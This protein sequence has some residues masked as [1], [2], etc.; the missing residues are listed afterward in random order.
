VMVH[1]CE[2]E[3]RKNLS[4]EEGRSVIDLVNCQEGRDE[5]SNFQVGNGMRSLEDLI[6]YQEDNHGNSYFQVGNYMRLTEDLI[7]CQ[8]GRSGLSSF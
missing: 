1:I 5:F 7:D 4:D 2:R 8:V 3:T 6:Y